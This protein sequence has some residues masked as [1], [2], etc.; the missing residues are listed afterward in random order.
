MQLG[1]ANQPLSAVCSS[2]GGFTLGLAPS[3]KYFQRA[4]FVG[5][6]FAY[7]NDYI[8]E[9]RF[10]Y[11]LKWHLVMPALA[12][13]CGYFPGR[14]LRWSEDL[15]KGVALEWGLRLNPSF[16]HYYNLL[17]HDLTAISVDLIKKRR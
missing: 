2:I 8:M 14:Q 3:S 7:Y 17:P 5:C 4:L 16:Y 9:R 1:P 11:F 12:L 10:E 6:Q 15:P 13:L